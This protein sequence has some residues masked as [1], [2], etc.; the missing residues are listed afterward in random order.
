M[1]PS[2][3]LMIYWHKVSSLSQCCPH[4]VTWR[5]WGELALS[6]C[7]VKGTVVISESEG[8]GGMKGSSRL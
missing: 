4:T 6:G 8:P 3:Q 1:S 5:G 2:L 7:S